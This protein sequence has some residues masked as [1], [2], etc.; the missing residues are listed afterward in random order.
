MAKVLILPHDGDPREA[1]INTLKEAQEIV[2]GYI[3]AVPFNDQVLVVN[4]DGK[5]KGLEYNV[6]A[7]NLCRD[8]RIGLRLHDY[9][10]GDAFL[11]GPPDND[12]GDWT[13]VSRELA[14]PI[15]AEVADVG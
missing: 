3:E 11:V 12:E 15:L 5:A 1:E 4:E 7:T 6:R 13:D 10:C 14:E 8:H 9:I 2:G